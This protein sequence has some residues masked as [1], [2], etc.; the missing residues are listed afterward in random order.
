MEIEKIITD[1]PFV[2]ELLYCVKQLAYKCVLKDEAQALKN[3]TIESI[4]NGDLYI[5]SLEGRAMFELFTYDEEAL[6]T[7]PIS[8]AQVQSY[9]NN[10]NNIP[11]MYKD[12]L[13][14]YMMQN[15]IV[16]GKQIGRAHV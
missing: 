8:D 6:R 4:K 5:A 1:N 3:E 11:D 15:P 16:T 12:L 7:L 13:R 10:I 2:D 14:Q 9:L